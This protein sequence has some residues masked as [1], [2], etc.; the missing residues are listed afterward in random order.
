MYRA[1]TYKIISNNIEP[2][3]NQEVLTLARSTDIAFDKNIVYLDGKDVTSHIRTADIDKNVSLVAAIPEI[4]KIL[5][6]LQQKTA[7]KY[8]VVMD[9]RDIG[10]VVL[11]DADYKFY[12]TAT[13]EERAMRRYKDMSKQYKN[14]ELNQVKQDIEMRDRLDSSRENSPLIIADD[15]IMID[16]TD[17]SIEQVIEKILNIMG[18]GL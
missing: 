11:P 18:C 1:L 2:Y 3:N 15:A 9:G 8:G 13:L 4:R 6:I 17:K 16:T 14:I 10:T 5:V 7:E 12:L